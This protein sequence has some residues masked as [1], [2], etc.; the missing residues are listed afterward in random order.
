METENIYEIFE[1]YLDNKLQFDERA[2]F[3][4][5]LETNENLKEQFEIYTQTQQF[6]ALENVKETAQFKAN[7]KQIATAN[8]NVNKPKTIALNPKWFAVAAA[9]TLLFGTWFF[10][11][12][13]NVDYNQYNQHETVSFTSRGQNNEVLQQA[14]TLFNTQKYTEAVQKFE[15]IKNASVEI[16]LTYA[17]CL[18]ET[19]NFSKAETILQNITKTQ[20]VFKNKASWY[21]ALS[22][23]KQ[24]N[25]TKTIEILKTLPTDAEEFEKAQE[26]IENLE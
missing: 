2:A 18:I 22:A 19:N 7:L 6:L 3:E 1:N 11:Q 9:I 10:T 23:L 15:T 5:S 13:N 26:I 4:T 12:N 25:K 16:N 14:E 8:N 21:L 24:N 20:N 17:I